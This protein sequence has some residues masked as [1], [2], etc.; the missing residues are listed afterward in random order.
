MRR[1]SYGVPQGGK[2]CEAEFYKTDRGGLVLNYDNDDS[3]NVVDLCYRT[4]KTLVNPIIEWDENDVWEFLNGNGIPHC[5]LYD[6]GF[7]RIGC[8]GCPMS[9]KKTEQFERWPKYKENYI[10]TFDR[11][12]ELRKEKGL[13]M[14]WKTSGDVMKW[15]MNN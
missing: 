14:T 6:E 15:W 7:K 4:T 9:N 5:C 10:K 11:M 12:L 1:N 2:A 13:E 8:I 3:K